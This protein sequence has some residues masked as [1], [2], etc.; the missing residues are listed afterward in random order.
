MYRVVSNHALA[1]SKSFDSSHSVS[2][3]VCVSHH[4]QSVS[5]WLWCVHHRSAE[6]AVLQI[7]PASPQ[8][9]A[10][11]TYQDLCI[12][13]QALLRWTQWWNCHE[14]GPLR[15][16]SMDSLTNT[17]RFKVVICLRFHKSAAVWLSYEGAKRRCRLGNPSLEGIHLGPCKGICV[18]GDILMLEYWR[19]L[20]MMNW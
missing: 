20:Q 14:A 6:I 5:T 15:T 11:K 8:R 17:Y 3:P 7:P 2:G 1:F 12:C 10:C 4:L 16:V 9:T 19:R 13:I 18:T